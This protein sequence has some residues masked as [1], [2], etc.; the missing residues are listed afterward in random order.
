MNR[1]LIKNLIT[2][3]LFGNA[4]CESLADRHFV[5]V[6]YKTIKGDQL[7]EK[8]LVGEPVSI[9]ELRKLLHTKILNFE[10][11]KID[12]EIR[13]ARGTTMMKYIPQSDHPKG[14]RASSP[15]VAT[16]FDLDKKAWRSVSK[17]SKEVVMKTAGEDRKPVFVVKNKDQEVPDLK[18]KDLDYVE[19]PTIDRDDIED[20]TPIEKPQIDIDDVTPVSMPAVDA[21]E[22]KPEYGWRPKGYG[23]PEPEDLPDAGEI[24]DIIVKPEAKWKPKVY[25]EPSEPVQ[26]L[27]PKPVGGNLNI[28]P[29]IEPIEPTLGPKPPPLT[30][31]PEEED[32]Y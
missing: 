28:T 19:D 31:E 7:L 20:I 32:E 11:I 13:P 21:I 16:F 23:E 30:I 1:F 5:G 15:R 3:I 25:K 27:L 6:V 22:K 9:P 26:I 29:P 18:I 12:G 14:I 10:F 24:K 4:I 8:L 2:E 17:R